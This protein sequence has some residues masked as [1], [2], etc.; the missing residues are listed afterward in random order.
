MDPTYFEIDD[1]ADPRLPSWLCAWGQRLS[2]EEALDALEPDALLAQ[3]SQDVGVD[4]YGD[5][6]FREPL[7]VLC[8]SLRTEAHLSAFGAHSIRQQLLQ[9]LQ[10]RLRVERLNAEHPEIAD[11]ELRAPIVI[12]GLPRSG[13]TFLHSLLGA[14]IRLRKLAEDETSGPPDPT[15]TPRGA[16]LSSRYA[17]VL[18]A[19]LPHMKRMLPLDAESAQEEIRLLG[20]SVASVLFETQVGL[21]SYRDWYLRTDQ[22][23]AYEYLAK[24]LRTLQWQ[25]SGG[26]WVLKTMQHVEQI[27]PLTAAFPDAIVVRTHRDPAS[28]VV[29]IATMLSYCQR[30]ITTEVH[31][32]R[33]GAYWSERIVGMTERC[34]RDREVV[35]ATRAV[36]VTLA[37]I[38]DRPDDVVARI[39]EVAGL[40]LTEQAQDMMIQLRT[41]RHPYRFGRVRYNPQ[42]L[43]ID[44]A[45]L[46]RRTERYLA[47]FDVPA[48]S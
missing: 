18:E 25:R 42:T 29:S 48:E 37:E 24:T 8:H 34:L 16:E 13:T 5:D 19:S 6:W 43:G 47:A 23:P 33:V 28:V 3:A 2:L 36:D 10:G 15:A 38:R 46:R 32:A 22:Q 26:R 21:P 17:Q 7:A 39:Y 44:V 27:T 1:L 14:D 9:L 45:V 20:L 31:P 35:P 11:V 4:D 40:R 12:A 41:Q 30:L